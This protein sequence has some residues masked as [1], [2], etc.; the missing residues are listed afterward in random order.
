M[1][2]KQWINENIIFFSF[3]RHWKGVYIHF[4]PKKC[5]RIFWTPEKIFN[6][7]SHPKSRKEMMEG[8]KKYFLNWG[9]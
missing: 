1:T 2:I 3:G 6:I 7:D 8:H 9:N 5:Y 4:F